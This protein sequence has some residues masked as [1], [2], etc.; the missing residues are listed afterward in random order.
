M[1]S[2]FS[3]DIAGS[4]FVHVNATAIGHVVSC[5]QRAAGVDTLQVPVE[6][7]QCRIVSSG[8]DCHR[9]RYTGVFPC[10]A[11]IGRQRAQTRRQR[12]AREDAAGDTTSPRELVHHKDPALHLRECQPC[13]YRRAARRLRGVRARDVHDV[14]PGISADIAAVVMASNVVGDIARH[15]FV[16]VDATAVGHIVSCAGHACC[17]QACKVPLESL[18]RVS[19][20]GHDSSH[21]EASFVS[22]VLTDST[23]H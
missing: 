13:R 2:N 8:S 16:H 14:Q 4:P 1:A 9:P 11:R 5:A 18:C 21:I 15:A 12:R 23:A 20:E 19:R 3:G 7:L 6:V 22:R 10:V 17:V